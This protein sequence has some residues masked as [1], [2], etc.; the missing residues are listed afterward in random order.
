MAVVVSSPK[1]AAMIAVYDS[2]NGG[3]GVHYRYRFV[4]V[5]GGEEV[6]GDDEVYWKIE[7]IGENQFRDLGSR[8]DVVAGDIRFDWSNRSPYEGWIYFNPSTVQMKRARA[9]DFETMDLRRALPATTRPA[10]AQATVLK[11]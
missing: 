9:T 1:G 2:Y 4:L 10:V 5:D 11:D 3:G 8:L 6:R 7:R